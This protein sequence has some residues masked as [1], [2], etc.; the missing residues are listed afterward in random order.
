MS[1]GATVGATLADWLEGQD[2]ERHARYREYLAFYEGEQWDRRRRAGETRLVVNYARALVRKVASYVFPEPVTFSVPAGRGVTPAAASRAEALLNDFGAAAD[3][4]ALDHQTLI[5]AAVLGDGAF[6]VT[7]DPVA[8]QP[9]VASI[10]P[11]GLWAWTWPDNVRRLRRV[12]H[13]YRLAAAEAGDLFGLALTGESAVT[14]VE[15]WWPDRVRIE[16][17]GQIVRDE[18]NPYGWIPYVI[19]PNAAKPHALWGESDLVDLI[20]VCRELNR[21]L[22]VISRILQ[23]S[24]NPIVVLENVTGSDGIR[25]DEGAVWELPED[26]RAYLLD[27]LSGGG[28]DL[29]I[30]YVELLYRALHDLAETPRTA[31][32]DSGRALSGAALEVEVQPLV[33]KVRRKRRVWDSVYRRRNTLLLDL[34]ERFGGEDLDGA[35]R[36]DPI[37]GSVL[38]SDRE[39]LVRA[40]ARLVAAGIHS[41]RTAMAALGIEDGEAEWRRVLE[42][43]ERIGDGDAG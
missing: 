16:V 27:M 36:S 34:W 28:V 33:Q 32:G 40:E 31:F 35:R 18:A 6:K 23:V 42:E 10:D 15:D 21:R 5:D 39:T 22:T 2:A 9:V 30:R 37:W 20:D 43:R 1:T 14:V 29:H 13:R 4:H 24:G 12:A 17:G 3:L 38:P 19:F 25:A 7:W 41:R 8:A 11:A 26:S